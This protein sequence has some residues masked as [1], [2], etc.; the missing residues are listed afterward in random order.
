ME[1]MVLWIF[2][3]IVAGAIA[4]GKGRSFFGLLL[5]SLALSPLIGIVTALVMSENKK[6][7]EEKQIESGDSKKC[8][9]CAELIKKEAKICRYCGRDIE[10]PPPAEGTAA[11]N[12][13][14]PAHAEELSTNKG[15]AVD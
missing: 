1:I 4:A 8:P 9:H 11:K 7:V 10:Q 14:E 5:L 6:K 2:F 13:T 15:S 12:N 3:S